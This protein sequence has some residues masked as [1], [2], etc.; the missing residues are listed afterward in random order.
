MSFSIPEG[1]RTSLRE[2]IGGAGSFIIL[3]K[4]EPALRL[5]LDDIQYHVPMFLYY[6]RL[7]VCN[8]LFE[9]LDQVSRIYKQGARPRS[10]QL[11]APFLTLGLSSLCEQ[12]LS[13]Y[14]QV[15]ISG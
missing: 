12:G 6:Y 10:S 13:M 11:T 7:M 9:N 8:F 4:V 2:S 14:G 3:V 5:D 15:A 1:S